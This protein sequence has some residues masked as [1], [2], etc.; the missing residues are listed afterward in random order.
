MTVLIAPL[1]LRPAPPRPLACR[2]CGT[3]IASE[4][5][6]ISVGGRP[7]RTTHTNPIGALCE[8]LTVETAGNLR[9]APER[10]EAHTWFEGYAWRVMDCATCGAQLGWR[11]EAVRE[12]LEPKTF[13]GLLMDAVR[14]EPGRE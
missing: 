12:G 10:S 6:A 3:R 13:Y 4:A 11:Y 8:V 9:L 7:R 2:G 5:D 1:S 14:R